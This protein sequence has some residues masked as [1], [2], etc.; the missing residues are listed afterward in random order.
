MWILTYYLLK[1]C[2]MDPKCVSIDTLNLHVPIVV[3]SDHFREMSIASPTAHRKHHSN[4]SEL[5]AIEQIRVFACSYFRF[6]PNFIN[7]S[8]AD[9]V[10]T[11]VR[12]C[13]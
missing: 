3:R 6:L 4:W 10:K 12:S 1:G 11:K 7:N 13:P 8:V 2:N 9:T 5:A